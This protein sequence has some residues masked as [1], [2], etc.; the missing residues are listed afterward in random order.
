[1]GRAS[2][3]NRRLISSS[4]SGNSSSARSRPTSRSS[5]LLPGG[6]IAG[7]LMD[8]SSRTGAS[9]FG[10]Q[11]AVPARGKWCEVE[12]DHHP[13]PARVGDPVKRTA[14]LWRQVGDDARHLGG[15]KGADDRVCL[16]GA[17]VD[18]HACHG[19]VPDDHAAD[20]C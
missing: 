1:M 17:F 18:D 14:N 12:T 19:A 3:S 9:S 2:P 11:R 5:V 4:S 10:V 20:G 7:R 6:A 16:D 8:R 15:R 13:A